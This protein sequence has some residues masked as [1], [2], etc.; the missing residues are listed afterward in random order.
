[1]LNVSSLTGIS[2]IVR[3]Y[4]ARSTTEKERS[5]GLAGVSG[6]QT[7]GLFIGPSK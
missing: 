6:S 3:S 7:M 5:L 2:A 1:M 4:I